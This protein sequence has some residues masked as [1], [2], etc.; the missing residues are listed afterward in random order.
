MGLRTVALA[1]G[2]MSHFPGTDRYSNPALDWDRQVLA[3]LAEGNLKS[4]AGYSEAEL[5][6][7]GNIELRCWAC[8]AGMLGERKPDTVSLEPSWHH[9]YASLGW[10]DAAEGEHQAHYP[11]IR[12]E[13]VALTAALHALAHQPQERKAY[14]KDPAGYADRFDLT[15]EQRGALLAMDVPAMVAMGTHPLVPFLARLQLDRDGPTG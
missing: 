15:A 13:L 3:R 11:S 2:G 1:S 12:P 5:D 14:R 7:T 6:E 8:A 9:N 10:Y 4:L